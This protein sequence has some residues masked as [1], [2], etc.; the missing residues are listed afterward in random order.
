MKQEALFE[1][2]TYP[3][4]YKYVKLKSPFEKGKIILRGPEG[5][6]SRLHVLSGKP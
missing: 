2:K 4:A 5:R 1:Y 6:L 3:R